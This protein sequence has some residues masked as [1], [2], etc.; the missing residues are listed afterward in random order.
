MGK[1]SSKAGKSSSSGVKLNS[2]SSSQR[3]AVYEKLQDMR[4]SNVEHIFVD[5]VTPI[6]PHLMR[7]DYTESIRVPYQAPVSGGTGNI[8]Y[9]AGRSVPTGKKTMYKTKNKRITRDIVI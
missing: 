9:N 2:A 3:E 6:N 5:S 7:V 1:G 8:N 4:A